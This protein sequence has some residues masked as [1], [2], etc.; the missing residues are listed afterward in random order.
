METPS[1]SNMGSSKT[2]T[3]KSARGSNKKT[4]PKSDVGSAKKTTPRRKR[5]SRGQRRREVYKDMANLVESTNT[6][7][8]IKVRSEPNTAEEITEDTELQRDGETVR[9]FTPDN[10]M[11]EIMLDDSKFSTPS[12]SLTQS[13]STKFVP[14][15]LN[16]YRIALAEVLNSPIDVHYFNTED[17]SWIVRIGSC[18]EEAQMLYMRLLLRRFNWI[19][20]QR[21]HYNEIDGISEALQE[22]VNRKLIRDSEYML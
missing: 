7:T 13:M 11:E 2:T 1:K 17:Y 18:T 14:Y 10:L 3:P 21:I 5:L 16:N 8:S 15:Y 4:T 9:P 19:N 12:Q 6:Y 20:V 22:L